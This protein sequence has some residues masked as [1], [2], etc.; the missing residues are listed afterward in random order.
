MPVRIRQKG[1]LYIRGIPPAL[2]SMFKS[3]CV[4]RGLQMEDVIPTLL[5]AFLA[6]PTK[7]PIRK[8][9][10]PSWQEPFPA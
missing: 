3:E 4:R 2:K 1:V 10:N 8:R 9:R 6:D 7:F 5:E